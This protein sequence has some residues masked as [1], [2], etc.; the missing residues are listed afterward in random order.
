NRDAFRAA[1]RYAP[2]GRF[3]ANFSADY[4]RQ[5]ESGAPNV[6]IGTYEGTSLALI[7]SL[8]DPNSP[9]YVPPPAPLPPPSFV[10]LYNL[11]AT[12]P[13]GL[14]GGIAGVTPGVV[15]NPLFGGPTLGSEDIID[16]DNDRLVYASYDYYHSDADSWVVALTLSLELDV[17]HV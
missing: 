16:L 3:E 10:D 15:P 7:G 9:A 6:L 11:L 2:G 8:A 14:Q 13:L 4:S 17:S 5:R 12:V 1:L